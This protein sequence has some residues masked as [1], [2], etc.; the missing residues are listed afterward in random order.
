MDAAA[1]WAERIAGAR[2]AGVLLDPP[3]VSDSP[4]DVATAYHAQDLL[5]QR[6]LAAGERPAGWK[7]GYTSAAM[8]AQ[9]G[10]TEPNCGPLTDAMLL[11]DGAVVPRDLLRQPR[12]EPEMAVVVGAD[13]PVPLP[14][15]GYAVPVA[16]TRVALEVVDS[17]WHDYRFTLEDNTADGSSAALVVLGA[18]LP[19]GTDLAALEVVLEVDGSPVARATGSAAMGSPL[20]ALHWLAQ[21]L[22]ARGERLLAGSVVITGGLTAAYP[23]APGGTVSATFGTGPG[24]RSV[25]VARQ[26]A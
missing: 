20:T 22:A 26:A 2:A 3:S 4:L 8:R 11:A 24:R 7:L 23:L 1:E 6:R 14:A 19:P 5:H 18:A 16:E 21:H 25:G 9:M 15:R 17:T 13:V 10:V 12:V